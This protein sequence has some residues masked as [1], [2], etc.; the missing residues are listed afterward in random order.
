MKVV[1]VILATDN[2][3]GI[4]NTSSTAI[5]TLPWSLNSEF[6]YYLSMARDNNV[7]FMV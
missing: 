7:F 3:D 5:H 2:K 6:K 4:G 1:N